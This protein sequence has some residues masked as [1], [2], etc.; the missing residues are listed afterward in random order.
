[1][2]QLF[3]QYEG[4]FWTSQNFQTKRKKNHWKTPKTWISK[5][6][7]TLLVQCQVVNDQFRFD[8]KGRVKVQGLVFML[9]TK[10]KMW[11]WG[12]RKG[13][14][15]GLRS[16][17]RRKSSREVEGRGITVIQLC[18]LQRL[19]PGSLEQLYCVKNDVV[20]IL[21]ASSLR[22]HKQILLLICPWI[23][24]FHSSCLGGL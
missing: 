22:N 7:K 16:S 10:S 9:D 23:A 4:I 21:L 20:L 19:G 15:T 18:A 12:G 14:N 24:E 17:H 8:D 1:M 2:F 11:E 13:R 6:R 3:L 5:F